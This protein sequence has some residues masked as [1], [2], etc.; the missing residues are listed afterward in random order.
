MLISL[1]RQ[2][3]CKHAKN[4]KH[5][6]VPKKGEH[7]CSM[8]SSFEVEAMVPGYSNKLSR[9]LAVWMGDHKYHHLYAIALLNQS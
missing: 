3:V 7:S 9:K 2:S 1:H 8:E 6:L 4:A 5:L